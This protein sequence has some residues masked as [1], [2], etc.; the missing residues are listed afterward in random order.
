VTSGCTATCGNVPEPGEPC[1]AGGAETAGCDLDCTLPSCGDAACN[2]AAGETAATCNADCPTTCGDALITGTEV[3]DGA[4]L[5]GQDCADHGYVATAGL[6][7][8]GSCASFVTT[9]CA[10]TCGN[11][12]EPGE[13]CDGGGVDTAGCDDDCTVPSCGDA[14]CNAAAGET[15]ATCSDDCGLAPDAGVP[16]AG[17][18]D[19]GAPDGGGP[20]AAAPEPDAGMPPGDEGGGCCD[21]SSSPGEGALALSLVTLLALRRRRR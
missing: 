18:A 4:N 16:D 11:V 3:C 5:G 7:C 2:E 21:A 10:A 14:H 19:A 17:A 8:A 1:D 9:G 20:D 13:P 15:E 6:T 12:P